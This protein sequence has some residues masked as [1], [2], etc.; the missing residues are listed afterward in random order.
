M[1]NCPAFRAFFQIKYTTKGVP[2]KKKEKK[3]MNLLTKFFSQS[4]AA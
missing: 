2:F 3:N 1:Y 4:G